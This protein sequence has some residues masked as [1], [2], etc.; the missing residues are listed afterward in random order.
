MPCRQ[1]VMDALEEYIRMGFPNVALFHYQQDL[2]LFGF[3]LPLSP[4]KLINRSIIVCFTTVLA[5]IFPFFNAIVGLL[6]A[7]AFFPLTV[8]FLGTP[9]G[10]SR[11]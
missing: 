4:L 3:I 9:F 6:G 7:I 5:C 10:R 11:A 8:S 1:P 2:N